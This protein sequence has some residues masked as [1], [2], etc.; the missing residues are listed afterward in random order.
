MATVQIGDI[1]V[2]SEFSAY[3]VE[4]SVEKSA[5]VT[6]G[7]VARNAAIEDHLRA[8]ADSFSVPFW[9]DLANDEANIASDDPAVFATPR[10]LSSGKQI[11]RK[12]FLHSSWAAMNLA[13]E[14]SGDN[15]LARIQDRAAA[16]WAR[17]AQRRLIASLNGILADNTTNDSS[18]MVKDI[19]G[20]TGD[21]AKFSAAAVIDAAGTLGDSM[22]DLIAIGMHSDTY[23]AALK[24][25]LIATVPDSQGG[26]IQTFRGLGILVDDGL[27][28][29]SSKYTTVLFGAGAAGYGMTAPRIAAGT[30]IENIPG[31]GNGGGQ[32]VLHSRVNLALHPLGFQWK[33][34]A[35]VGD[36]PT[37]AELATATNWDRVAERKHVPLAFLIHKL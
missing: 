33:E 16:Y 13:S 28:L 11:V 7:I 35:V 14:L 1:I 5:L 15:A 10:K 34:T 6:S 37:I 32:Q 27:P 2:P 17:Q 20:G 21:A 29:A 9:K 4:N 3:L 19:S 18:D 23:K 25:D 31:A 30:E 12:S 26:F 22:R 8:G 36:S 24:A